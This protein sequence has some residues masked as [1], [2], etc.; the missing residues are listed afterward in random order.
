MLLSCHCLVT[1]KLVVA[2]LHWA[3]RVTAAR[4]IA[5]VELLETFSVTLL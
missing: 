1:V 4:G 5:K 2:I 3:V